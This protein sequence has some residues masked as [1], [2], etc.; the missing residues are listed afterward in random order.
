[1]TTEDRR[2]VA[3]ATAG[4]LR[5]LLIDDAPELRSLICEVIERD[6]A[7]TV[8]GM[9]DD[10][11]AGVTAAG[12]LQ[13]DVIVLDL[14]MP[15]LDGISALPELRAICP[16]AKIIVLSGFQKAPLAAAVLR[17]G[18]VGYLEKGLSPHRLRTDLLL[19]VGAL[20]QI[21][22]I[23]R[24]ASFANEPKA[25]R[26]AR[27]FVAA[28][29]RDLMCEGVL[30]TVVLLTSELVTNALL[31]GSGAP[32]VVVQALPATLRVDVHDESTTWPRRRSPDEGGGRGLHLLDSLA[33]D[34]GV[35]SRPGGKAVWF[36]VER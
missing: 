30:D 32:Q 15:V 36:T 25:V 28:A 7:F 11:R 35:E 23:R 2:P 29:M 17:G 18:A 34:W 9:S 16:T 6:G 12:E 1:V 8:V 20:H 4:G 31:H 33:S 24:S 22:D 5:T 19:L 13:P 27:T 21:D 26:A 14:A 3:G 10:G